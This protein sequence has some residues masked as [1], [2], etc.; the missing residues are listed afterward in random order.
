LTRGVGPTLAAPPPLVRREPSLLGSKPGKATPNLWSALDD[1]MKRWVDV[2]PP[3]A[4]DTSA[5]AAAAKDGELIFVSYYRGGDTK[6]GELYGVYKSEAEAKKAVAEVKKWA[7]DIDKTLAEYGVKESSSRITKIEV[8][9]MGGSASSKKDEAKS[10]KSSLPATAEKA[11]GTAHPTLSKGELK[12]VMPSITSKKAG[13]LTSALNS[14]M[15][16]FGIT[17]LGR[18]A[19]FLAQL[20]VESSELKRMTERYTLKPNFKLPGVKSKKAYSAKNARDYFNYWYGGRMGN[21]DKDDGWKYRGRGPIMLT[22]RDNYAAVGKALGIDL[23]K[24]PDLAADPAIGIRIAAWFWK[25]KG[26]NQL[27][28]KGDFTEITRRING[29][30]NHLKERREYYIKAIDA[31][32]R[33]H[34]GPTATPGAVLPSTPLP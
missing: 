17:T 12:S 27:A 32:L 33:E 25:D 7:A 3:G 34:S 15:K 5:K 8:D 14:A 24:N 26:L 10:A 28:D 23:I 2:G 6:G 20:A 21:K 18:Q 1:K 16:E 22:G 30:Y 31:L 11:L 13:A 9:R 29:G 4:K 19:A